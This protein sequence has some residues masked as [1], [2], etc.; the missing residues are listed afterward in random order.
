MKSA[1]TLTMVLLAAAALLASGCNVTRL[2]IDG[3]AMAPALKDGE[4]VV[5]SRTVAPLA[6]GDIVAFRYPR[7]ETK[8]FVKRIVGLPGERIQMIEGRVLIDGRALD[9]A[10]VAEENRS[11]ESWGP[12]T[13]A[14]GEYFM[15]GDNRR[16]SSDSRSWGAVRQSAIWAKISG[17]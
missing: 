11:A 3:H 17:R 16:N 5:A 8:S 10:Y 12:L 13:I 4:S 7:D 2:N 15:L 14:P 1:A 6:R 9:E